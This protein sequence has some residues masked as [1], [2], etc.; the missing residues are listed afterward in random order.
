[1]VVLILT[2]VGATRLET[3]RKALESDFAEAMSLA[4]SARPA[5]TPQEAMTSIRIVRA[6]PDR[7]KYDEK[8]EFNMTLSIRVR[9]AFVRNRV[10]LQAFY[11][12]EPL[13]KGVFWRPEAVE[14]L[15]NRGGKSTIENVVL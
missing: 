2:T 11:R 6:M 7:R 10:V 3:A 12:V 4:S 1:M 8:L 13:G 9:V 5:E 15:T 14:M